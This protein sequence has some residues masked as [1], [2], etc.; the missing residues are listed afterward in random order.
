MNESQMPM[1]T[2]T[3]FLAAGILL[4]MLMT[5]FAQPVITTQPQDQTN[6]VGTTATL[7]VVANGT[8]PVSYQWQKR[9][10]CFADLTGRTNAV[11][12]LANVQTNDAAHYR[13]VVKDATGTN[14]STAAL[15]SV[16]LPERLFISQSAPGLVTLSWQGNMVLLKSG[17]YSGFLDCPAWVRVAGSSPVTLPIRNGP[18]FFKL[19]ALPSAAELEVTYL[20]NMDACRDQDVNACEACVAAYFLTAPI[21]SLS[22]SGEAE[23]AASIGI[24]LGSCISAAQ[25]YVLA[26]LRHMWYGP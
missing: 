25:A 26:A 14:I 15:L 11:L 1:K 13:V 5:S 4:A 20:T 21:G 7:S 9:S 23:E 3:K 24:S 16:A 6:Y 22:P 17:L 8:Q 10:T 19:V 18:Q 12:T 2:K